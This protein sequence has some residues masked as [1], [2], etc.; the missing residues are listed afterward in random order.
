MAPKD[1][2]I[3]RRTGEQ[4]QSY[5]TNGKRDPTREELNRLGIEVAKKGTLATRKAPAGRP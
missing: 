1:K 2:F 5:H 4:R 3:V